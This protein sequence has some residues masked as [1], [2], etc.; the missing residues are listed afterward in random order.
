MDNM[1]E[2]LK[3]YMKILMPV[4]MEVGVVAS[5]ESPYVSVALAPSPQSPQSCLFSPNLSLA[6]GDHVLLTRPRTAPIWTV[7]A[8]LSRP[9]KGFSENTRGT[10]TGNPGGKRYNSILQQNISSVVKSVSTSEAILFTNYLEMKGGSLLVVYNG[11][12]TFNAVAA[13]VNLMVETTGG[14]KAMM[15]KT[16]LPTTGDYT[17]NFSHLFAGPFTGRCYCSVSAYLD[18]GTVNLTTLEFSLLEV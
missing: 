5:V 13:T 14:Q 8:I 10:P 2:A 3:R 9:G 6:A 7:T 12:A 11:Y 16:R 4:D 17:V 15:V 18:T 1:L